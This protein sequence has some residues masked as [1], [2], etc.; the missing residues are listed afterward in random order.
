MESIYNLITAAG[1]IKKASSVGSVTAEKLGSLLEGIV[2]RLQYAATADSAHIA[3]ADKNA[4]GAAVAFTIDSDGKTGTQTY[5]LALPTFNTTTHGAGLLT[6]EAYLYIYK[7]ALDDAKISAQ[8]YDTELKAAIGSAYAAADTTNLKAAKSYTDGQI[9]TVLKQAKTYADAEVAACKTCADTYAEEMA[10]KALTDAKAYTDSVTATNNAYAA[11]RAAEALSAAKQ[12]SDA[13][14]GKNTA[15]VKAYADTLLT[16]A[17]AYADTAVGNGNYSVLNLAKDAAKQYDADTLATAK[18]YADQKC[19]AAGYSALNAAKEA[20]QTYDQAVLKTAKEYTDTEA[21][22]L[23]S[24]IKSLD[25]NGVTEVVAGFEARIAALEAL[26]LLQ[27]AEAAN[28]AEAV[29]LVEEA[30][31]RAVADSDTDAATAPADAPSA[32]EL[33]GKPAAD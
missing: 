16:Q 6:K 30:E 19:G 2:G 11:D 18:T 3:V 12:Y 26:L 9:E 10:Q 15:S 21:A 33:E 28:T 24:M 4:E 23:E 8:A 14:C 32:A 1:E 29:A 20:A 27:T 5:K 13:E 22:R 31:S 17:K 7:A 25:E